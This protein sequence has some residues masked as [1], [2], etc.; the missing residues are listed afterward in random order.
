MLLLVFRVIAFYMNMQIVNQSGSIPPI[1]DKFKEFDERYWAKLHINSKLSAAQAGI[2]V[3][4]QELTAMQIS[5][6]TPTPIPT[7]EEI[8]DSGLSR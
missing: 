2:P 1:A 6:E 5:I 7:A 4:Q 3:N 8:Y